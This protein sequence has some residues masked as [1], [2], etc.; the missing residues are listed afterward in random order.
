MDE[1]YVWK[2]D[3]QAS[4]G[5]PSEGEESGAGA[6]GRESEPARTVGAVEIIEPKDA[7]ASGLGE[8]IQEVKPSRARVRAKVGAETPTTDKQRRFVKRYLSNGKDIAD[9]FLHVTQR[10]KRLPAA[11]VR[12]LA[13]EM[14]MSAGVQYL[15]SEADVYKQT[16]LVPVFKK[17]GID[18]ARIAQ[19][20]ARI[21]FSD[22]TQVMAWDGKKVV[23]KPSDE[24]SDDVK[25][26]IAEV[27][28]TKDGVVVKQHNKVD[29]LLTLGKTLGMFREEVK[30]QDN[31]VAV[32]FVINKGD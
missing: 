25:S 29:A 15:L 22:P 5:A 23:I 26:T 24:L 32:Q 19:E 16:N 14:L 11:S 9:A 7:A 13:R 8:D 4:R 6:R 18:E 30:P 27:K 17:Y 20:L 12:K 31:R 2:V 21:A 3:R 1:K 10:T 28:P